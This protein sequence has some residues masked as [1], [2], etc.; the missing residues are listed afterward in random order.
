MH[1][2]NQHNQH[3]QPHHQDPQ[4]GQEHRPPYEVYGWS[5]HE[6]RT[7]EPWYSDQSESLKNM[8]KLAEQMRDSGRWLAI[9]LYC[10]DQ[11]APL[12]SWTVPSRHVTLGWTRTDTFT[13]TFPLA[14]Y[15]DAGEDGLTE[16]L[17]HSETKEP[18]TFN[19]STEREITRARLVRKRAAR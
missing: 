8:L 11:R 7:C 17:D 1:H 14:D 10:D 16:L 19:S 15:I 12:W 5:P 9:R 4:L 6:I 2:N 13:G 3:D 18:A